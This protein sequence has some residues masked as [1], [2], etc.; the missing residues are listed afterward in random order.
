MVVA[1]AAIRI[2]AYLTR[3]IVDNGLVKRNNLGTNRII[4]PVQVIGSEG[5]DHDPAAWKTGA[6]YGNILSGFSLQ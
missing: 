3:K 1:V 4:M 6:F 5:P 2:R